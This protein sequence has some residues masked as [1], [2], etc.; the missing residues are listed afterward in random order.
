M[1]LDRFP[2]LL[3]LSETEKLQLAEELYGEALKELPHLSDDEIHAELERSADEYRRDPTSVSDW[4][5]VKARILGR[6]H[7]L[8]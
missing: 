8:R 6:R 5:T 4:Q 1:I 3:A 2:E 7:S